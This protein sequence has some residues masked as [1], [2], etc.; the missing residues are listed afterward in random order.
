MVTATL[1]DT[2]SSNGA[3]DLSCAN[4]HPKAAP[5]SRT[6]RQPLFLVCPTCGKGFT[7][8]ASSPVDA[9]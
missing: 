9:G 1:I 3:D 5:N 6:P 2:H 8:G 7:G 4:S